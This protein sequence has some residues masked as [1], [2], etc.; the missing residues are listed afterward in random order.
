MMRTRLKFCRTILHSLIYVQHIKFYI[1][2]LS[3]RFGTSVYLINEN[4]ARISSRTIFRRNTTVPNVVSYDTWHYK[5]SAF[6]MFY[7]LGGIHRSPRPLSSDNDGH[8]S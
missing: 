8:Q 6:Y 1:Y 4:K 2:E 5:A 7:R 3:N